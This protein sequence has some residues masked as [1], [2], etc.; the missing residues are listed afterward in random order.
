MA[1]MTSGLGGSAGYGEQSFKTTGGVSGNLDDGF[2]TVNVTSVFGAGGMNINGTSYTSLYISSNGLITFQ[3]GVT[4]YTPTALTSLGQPSLSPFWTDADISKGGDIYWDLDPSTGKITITWANVAAF[5]G[6]GTNSFQVILTATGGGDFSI[7]YI[8]QSIGYTNGYTGHATTGF[9]DGTTQTLLAGSGDPAVLTN[10]SENDFET[11]DPAGVYGLGFEAGG[12]FTGDGI[13][14]GT[15]GNDLINTAYTGDPD[16]DRVDA[17]DA[18]GFSGTTGDGDYIRAGAGND[19][20]SSGLGN[21]IVFGDDGSDSITGGYGADTVDGGNQNDTIDGGSGNDSLLGGTGDDV[22]FGGVTGAAAT[23]IATYTSITTTS[24][25]QLVTAAAGRSNFSVN[26]VSN[27]GLTSGSYSGVSGFRIGNGDSNETHTHTASS[28]IAGG[29]IQFNGIDSTEAMTIRIDGV[30]INLNTAIDNGLVTFNGGLVSGAA[31]YSIN[32]SGQIVRNGTGTANPAT[33]GTLTINIPYTSLAIV[34]SGSNTNSTTSGFFYNYAVNTQPLNVATEAGGN[35]ALFGG[36]GNDILY[37]GD[38]NDTLSGGDDNDQVFGGTGNDSLSGDLGNDTLQGEDGDDTLAGGDGADSLLG[39]IGNDSLLGDGGAD[40]LSG[41]DGNDR[42]FGG[43][44]NDSLLGDAGADTLSGGDGDDRLFGGTGNDSLSGDLGNDTLQGDDGD[45]TLS[46]GDGADS[47]IGGIGND[48][49]QGGDGIDTLLGGDGNDTLVGGVGADSLDGGVGQDTADY[50]ASSAAVTVNLQSGLGSGGDAQGDTLSNI[51]V[52]IGSDNNDVLTA[53]S[54]GSTLFG[55]LGADSV[56]GGTSIDALYG[57]DGADRL[58][59]LAGNDLLDGG[60][61]DDT[62]VGGLGNDTLIGGAGLDLAVFAGPVTDYSFAYAAGA[63][64]V[65]DSVAGRDGVDRLEG[66]E[67]AS[68]NGVT[69]R[70]IAGDD[71]ANTT[72]QGP[73]DGTP[74]LII[75]HA[76]NDS[77]VG[78]ATRDVVFGGAGNDTLNGGDGNDTLLGEADDDLLRGDGGDDALFGGTGNDILQGGAGNDRLEGGDGNDVLEGG[79][80]ADSLFGGSGNDTIQLTGIGDVVDGGANA[81][82]ND[83]LDLSNW[84]WRNTNILYDPGNSQSG[85]VQFLDSNGTI[86]GSMQFSNF[87]TVIPCFTPGTLITTRRGAVPVETLVAGDEVLTRDHG[88]RPL[89]WTGQRVL[90]AAD[91]IANPQLCPVQIAAGA[92]GNGLPLRDLLVSPQHRMLIE[93]GRAEMLFGEA[94]VLVAALHLVGLPGIKTVFLP[95]LTYVHVMFEGH[96][97]VCSE[98]AWSESFQP[99]QRMLKAMDRDQADEI[100]ALFPNLS[101]REVAFASARLTLKAYEAQV[102]LAA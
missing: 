67:F 9:S 68:F 77:A 25:N 42:L 93:G 12:T 28:Q 40:T 94:E 87:E 4:A 30:T 62:L 74:S 52:V 19:T 101:M 88:Y 98:G 57:G 38:G 79:D 95:G 81:G 39:G 24:P 16:G 69:Y 6:P 91:L 7:E 32:T 41:G 85:T 51:E 89:V 26:S 47:L 36:A 64:I 34:A 21:D 33:I 46:G 82:D 14:D 53:R 90:S 97:I 17:G 13:V 49:L 20:V 76:G 72:L 44:G 65:T 71:G 54:T 99:A 5:Q 48:S 80:G 56:Y 102:L 29:R 96:E 45:D 63:L 10:Y 73:N 35:D 18:T 2:V 84:G 1:T 58:E 8:Y 27:E 22:I 70:V 59:G 60:A 100:R 75:A 3:S 37:G 66:V 15:A 61:G 83:V 31:V 92:L 55:G 23:Y 78:Q 50:S 86:L 43:A 11:N